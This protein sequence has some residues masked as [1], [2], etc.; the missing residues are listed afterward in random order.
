MTD[1]DTPA[2]LYSDDEFDDH[3]L[4]QLSDRLYQITAK[5]SYGQARLWFPY[6]YLQDKTTYNTTTSYKLKGPLDLSRFE[7]AIQSVIKRHQALRMSFFTDPSTGH[8][9][10]AVSPDSSFTLKRVFPADEG[11][12]VKREQDKI[13]QYHY[14][15][16][17]G[18]VFIAT[19]LC[20]SPELH[21]IIFGYHHIILDAVS[22]Q[23]FLQDLEMFYSSETPKIGPATKY[24]DFAIKQRRLMESGGAQE[25]RQYWRSEFIDL[26]PM[27]PLFPFSRV[28]TRKA[29][30][31]YEMRD[32]FVLLDR[33]LVANVK[34]ASATAKT[35]TFHFYLATLQV[36][37]H[38]FLDINEFC[39]GIT[40]ANRTDSAFMQTVGFLLDSLPLR[41]RIDKEETFSDRLHETRSKVYSAL[42]NSGISLDVIL[43]DL[44][45]ATSPEAPPLFQILINYRMGALKHKSIADVQLEYLDYTDVKHPFDFALSID[46]AEGDGSL[47]LS[48]QDYLYD[49]AGGDLLLETYVH[50]LETLSANVDQKIKESPLFDE[51]QKQSSLA[52]STGPKPTEIWPATLSLRIDS[53][54][55]SNPESVAIRDGKTSLTY[56]QMAE[57]TDHIALELHANGAD[58][59]SYIAVCCE[60][61]PD[62]VCSLLAILRLGAIYIPLDIRQSDERLNAIVEESGAK[63][64]VAHDMTQD[65]VAILKR[66]Y[67][68]VVNASK[69]N[70]STNVAAPNR[71]NGPDPAFIMFTSGSTGRPKGIVLTNTNVVTHVAAATQR[72]NIKREI[73]L[74]QSSYGYDASLAQIFYALANGGTLVM[75]NNRQE[76]SHIAALMAEEQVTLTLFTPSEYTVL[77]KY[78]NESLSS[79]KSWR[80]AMSAGEAFPTN[81]KSR[82]AELDLPKLEVFNSYGMSNTFADVPMSYCL[83]VSPQ[84]QRKLRWPQTLA[85][86]TIEK[87]ASV[88]RKF[89]LVQLW[90]TTALISL[91]RV[92]NSYLLDGWERFALRGPPLH[93]DTSI[94]N[95]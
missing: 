50:L 86:S 21:T 65:R 6:V 44:N 60:P 47:T 49:Q 80:I 18:D 56:R 23:L 69:I 15:L 85:W 53:I 93:Q 83:L 41:F 67:A 95:H 36:L 14:D 27:L 55:E 89:L 37:L 34:Q 82:F 68:R 79:C 45:V 87:V 58:N 28:K 61:C 59:G 31:R 16:E 12:D 52:L 64:I 94:M 19:I 40:D 74:Q 42:G 66:D 51:R 72:M 11:K 43:E 4:P 30:L 78:G 90:R 77:F 9:I 8:T 3:E 46:E 39:I 88:M 5:M 63:I 22:W 35:T 10:Q 29:Q 1:A 17:I 32:C 57:R 33:S 92:T 71:S 48:M 38:R 75:S 20:H 84:V 62:M 91:I 26:P 76:M 73:V 24:T 25:K 54:I 70:T 13:K 7:R 2:T 81:L